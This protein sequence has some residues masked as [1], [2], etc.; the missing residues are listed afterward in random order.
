MRAR[1]ARRRPTS[2]RCLLEAL[3]ARLILSATP[4]PVTTVSS[5]L[6]SAVR[7]AATPQAPLAGATAITG[8]GATG[9]SS[10][11]ATSAPINSYS[12]ISNSRMEQIPGLSGPDIGYVSGNG[13]YVEYTVSAA[14]GV[15]N[16]GLG[17]ASLGGADVQIQVNGVYAGEIVAGATGAWSRFVTANA[18]IQLNAGNNTIRFTATNWTQYNINSVVLTPINPATATDH[19]GWRSSDHRHPVVF[20]NFKFQARTSRGQRHRLRFVQWSLC[21]IHG[22]RRHGGQLCA[23]RGHRRTQCIH[24]KCLFERRVSG[25]FSESRDRRLVQN[26][27]CHAGRFS[28]R[29]YSNPP[30]CGAQWH[31]VQHLFHWTGPA[32]RLGGGGIFQ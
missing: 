19:G 10:S 2:I 16:L 17:L 13:A 4:L 21:R 12:A 14:N 31:A 25:Q 6:E 18:T 5:A 1:Q 15:F 9:V 32:E 23:D 28:L 27:H 29:G 26:C 22:Q 3:E 8:M 7:A 11:G 20:G 30:L 24:I